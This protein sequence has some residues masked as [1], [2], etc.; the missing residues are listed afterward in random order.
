MTS[1][2]WHGGARVRHP[3]E[4]LDRCGQCGHRLPTGDV[5]PVQTRELPVRFWPMELQ[6]RRW[7]RR[8]WSDV[9]RAWGPTGL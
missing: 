3:E 5:V 9:R 2:P 6:R 8:T 7:A 4:D 1:C